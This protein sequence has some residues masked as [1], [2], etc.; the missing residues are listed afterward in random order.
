M[1]PDG[2]LLS[3]SMSEV[4]A[5]QFLR[6]W[7]IDRLLKGDVT[8]MSEFKFGQSIPESFAFS[9]DGRYL[10]GS[11]YYTG[12]SNVFRYEVANGDIQ[13][14]SN[15]ETGFFRPVPLAD[16]RLVV[17]A[18]TAAGFVPGTIDPKPI[19]DVSAITFLGSEVAG[20]Y[21]SS[22]SGRC[23]R[24]RSSTTMP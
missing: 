24:P 13:G 1:S 15:A 3:A 10:Y 14:V 12:A 4:S 8:S 2:K 23:H 5:D 9:K 21:Q 7:R 22:R 11:S 18:Y 20:K 6:V 19:E 17:L 16:G